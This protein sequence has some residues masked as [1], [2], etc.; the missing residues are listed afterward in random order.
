MTKNRSNLYAGDY[1][2]EFENESFV[3]SFA[4]FYGLASKS[5]STY[6]LSLGAVTFDEDCLNTQKERQGS[7]FSWT[8]HTYDDEQTSSSSSNNNYGSNYYSNSNYNNYG[9]NS[10]SN[11]NYGR[12]SYYEEEQCYAYGTTVVRKSPEGENET[13]AIED[14]KEGEQILV[15]STQGL[16]FTEVIAVDLHPS[17]KSEALTL[18]TKSGK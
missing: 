11:Y 3:F 10:N 5:T 18:K 9:S 7:A 15:K 4:K 2:D 12:S 14:V 16:I 6:I 13:V 8:R 1:G 17:A